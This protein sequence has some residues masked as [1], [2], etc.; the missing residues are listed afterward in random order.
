MQLRK[1]KRSKAKIRLG[2]SGPSGSGKTYTALLLAK[3]LAGGDLS[4]VAIIDSENGSADLYE[5]LGE[6]NVLPIAAPYTPEKYTEAIQ[7]CQKAGMLVTIIDS[8]THEWSGVGGCLEIVDAIVQRSRSGNSYTAWKDVTPRHQKFIDAILQADMHVITTV[9]SKTDYI[10]SEDSN[11]KKKIEKAGMA[12]VTRDGFEY[13]LT[14]SFEVDMQHRGHVSK[15]RTGLYTNEVPVVLGE[16]D[17]VK[18]LEWCESG[19]EPEIDKAVTELNA[20]TTLDELKAIKL[21]YPES[22]VKDQRFQTAGQAMYTKLIA[23]DKA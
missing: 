4:K 21:K 15:D 7:A 9:R 8:I 1:A 12:Q 14:L 5:H 19:A 20:A 13:E 10:M 17:G 2:L 18:I 23:N 6:Y 22:I 3:G 11:G 16:A